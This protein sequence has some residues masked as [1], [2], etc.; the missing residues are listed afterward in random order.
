MQ[1]M[2]KVSSKGQ[3]TLPAG[4]RRRFNIKPGTYLHIIEEES[5]FRVVPTSEGIARLRGQVVVSG[6]QDF[7]KARQIALEERV[8]EKNSG[9]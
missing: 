4:L 7:R 6:I 1:G 5:D 2:V 3:I 8:H 9:D